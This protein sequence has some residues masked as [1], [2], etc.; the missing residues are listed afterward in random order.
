MILKITTMT[1]L[2]FYFISNNGQDVF[3]IANFMN[4]HTYV[5]MGPNNHKHAHTMTSTKKV[6]AQQLLEN[7][8]LSFFI[9]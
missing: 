2:T 1:I 7:Q 9:S 4:Y 3:R 8:F 6:T 5:R